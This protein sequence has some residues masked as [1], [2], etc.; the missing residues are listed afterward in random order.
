MGNYA[1]IYGY[2]VQGSRKLAH[3]LGDYLG[4]REFF[5][6][7]NALICEKITYTPN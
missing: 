5:F 3:K 2:M 1:R 6:N 4:I 7:V